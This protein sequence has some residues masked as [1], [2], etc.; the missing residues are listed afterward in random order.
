MGT[1]QN[2][3]FHAYQEYEEDLAAGGGDHGYQAVNA[4]TTQLQDTITDLANATRNDQATMMQLKL[5]NQRLQHEVN[6]INEKLTK[7]AAKLNTVS[8]TLS[9]NI[10]TKGGGTRR[11]RGIVTRDPHCTAYCWT[12]GRT[13]DPNHTSATC[14]YPT[15][16]HQP[17]ATLTNRMNGSGR[18]CTTQ[19]TTQ[20]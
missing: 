16:G 10:N 4:I 2:F 13:Y 15:D 20:A 3:F 14:L 9:N 11:G 12:H 19:A 18:G 1:I 5:A 8:Q 6:K 7:M 17:T